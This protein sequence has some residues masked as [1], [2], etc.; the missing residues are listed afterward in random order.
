MQS[1]RAH[2]PDAVSSQVLGGQEPWPEHEGAQRAQ[3][4][5][6]DRQQ[7]RGDPACALGDGGRQGRVALAALRTVKDRPAPRRN[8]RSTA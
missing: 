7:R 1:G 5:P 4:A 2:V 6:V 3:D 8:W